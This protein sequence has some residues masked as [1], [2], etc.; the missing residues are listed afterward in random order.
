MGAVAE[1]DV[2]QQNADL[3]VGERARDVLV[4][5]LR[6]DHR[7]RPAARVLVVA[8]VDE[9]MAMEAAAAEDELG[10]AAQRAAARQ[11]RL[12]PSRGHAGFLFCSVR[13]FFRSPFR[14][15]RAACGRARRFSRPRKQTTD[16]LAQRARRS[17]T[18]SATRG[19]GG[20]ESRTITFVPASRSR[21]SIAASVPS[22]PTRSSRS[23]P[24]TP[25]PCETPRRAARSGRTPPAA[26]CPRR[27]R[28]RCRRAAPRWR[29]RAARRDE[30]R[31]AIRPHQEQ[32]F[33]SPCA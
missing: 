18:A 13:F 27:T 20:L 11:R 19:A 7:V 5:Q 23:R 29:K 21:A 1:H 16:R 25:M 32:S 24:P 6:V 26:P 10:L 15:L 22:A 17:S 28:C 3:G 4:A 2:H 30:R 14:P 31:A 12:L 33:R 9:A 8:Q